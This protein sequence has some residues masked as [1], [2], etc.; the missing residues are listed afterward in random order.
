MMNT[1]LKA[2]SPY[3]HPDVNKLDKVTQCSKDQMVVIQTQLGFLKDNIINKDCYN[4]NDHHG[5][6]SCPISKETR[7]PD[8]SW[9]HDYY[10]Q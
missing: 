8:N 10:K 3:K 5:W 7:C 6:Y 1:P 9:L 4:S 2:V